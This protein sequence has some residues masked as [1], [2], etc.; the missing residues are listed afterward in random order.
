MMLSPPGVYRAQDDTSLLIGIMDRGGFADGR[1]VL[2]VGTG[3]GV[4]AIAA[5]LLGS[6]EVTGIDDDA[7]AIESAQ[8]NMALNAGAQVALVVVHPHPGG[9]GSN[10]FEVVAPAAVVDLRELALQEFDGLGQGHHGRLAA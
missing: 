1:D 7:D 5:S 2:D 8:A 9:E 4:L 6:T 10:R 3:S